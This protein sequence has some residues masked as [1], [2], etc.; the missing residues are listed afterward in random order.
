MAE[1]ELRGKGWR[2]GTGLGKRLNRLKHATVAFRPLPH[3]ASQP[4]EDGLETQIAQ[5]PS[6]RLRPN[7]TPILRQTITGTQH[8]RPHNPN[9]RQLHI[10]KPTVPSTADVGSEGESVSENPKVDSSDRKSIPAI[11]KPVIDASSAWFHD[12]ERRWRRGLRY[13]NGE[14]PRDAD[15]VNRAVQAWTRKKQSADAANLPETVKKACKRKSAF[16]RN[17]EHDG[18]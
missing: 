15:G 8:P 3:S 10:A 7:I 1:L 6:H 18:P 12:G 4:P 13:S 11:W 9:I 5:P 17:L 2:D 16:L 14:M